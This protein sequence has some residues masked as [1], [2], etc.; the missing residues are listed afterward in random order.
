MVVASDALADLRAV[1]QGQPP[2]AIAVLCRSPGLGVRHAETLRAKYPQTALWL[3]G[4]RST[5]PTRVPLAAF[6]RAGLD[7]WYAPTLVGEEERLLDDA[8]RRASLPADLLATH[9]P[10]NTIGLRAPLAYTIVRYCLRK[11]DRRLSVENVARWFGDHRRSI[12]RWLQRETGAST[13]TW[14]RTGRTSAAKA[15]R[16][17]G[18]RFATIA[19][20]LGYASTSGAQMLVERA[21][22]QAQLEGGYPLSHPVV[23]RN[24]HARN[25]QA[26]RDDM[27]DD[28]G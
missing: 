5:A 24:A 10:T 27:R 16:E 19:S 11:A 23:A 20:V 15:L 13:A 26:D 8:A 14:P 28:S 3:V 2:T 22:R 6:A 12:D 9:R 4:D 17:D 7:D 1:V 25:L 21:C 18:A